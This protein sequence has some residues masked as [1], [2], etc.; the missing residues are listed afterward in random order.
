MTM[1]CGCNSKNK[2]ELEKDQI[3]EVAI[4]IIDTIENNNQEEFKSYFTV[5][6]IQTQD[7]DLGIQYVFDAYSGNCKDIK[8]AGTHIGDLFDSGN[9]TKIAFSYYSVITED[10]EYMLYFEYYLKDEIN[11]N[12][13]K[14]SKLKLVNMADV[15]DKN[16]YN[17]GGK[18]NRLGIYNPNWD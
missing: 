2:I 17:F 3:K 18:Y 5:G 13:S 10:S 11:Y 4:S 14:I 6:A 16:S 7:F 15:R 8:D 12:T 9:Q 1:F